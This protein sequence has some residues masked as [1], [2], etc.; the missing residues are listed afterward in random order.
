MNVRVAV[1]F[2]S[3][4]GRTRA[5]AEA[6]ARGASEIENV[7]ATTYDVTEGRAPEVRVRADA[8]AQADAIVFGCPTYMGSVSADMKRFMDDTAAVW[9]LQGWQ[10]KVAAGFTHSAA[11]SGDKLG[12]L[13]QL[14]VFAAQ[15]GMIWV[16]LGLPPTYASA[17]AGARAASATNRLG[18]HLGAMAQSA[19]GSGARPHGSDVG[20]CEHLGRRVA[21]IA[22]ALGA[23]VEKPKTEPSRHPA[24]QSWSFPRG[25]RPE[26]PGVA[27]TNLRELAARRERLEHHLTIVAKLGDAQLEIATASEPLYF[28]HINISDEYVVALP[29]G[30]DLVDRFPLRTFLSDAKT[31]ADVG[32]YNHRIGDLVLHPV[33]SL[34]WPGKLRPPFEPFAI[35]KGMRRAGVSL[36]YCAGAPTPA[37][38]GRTLSVTAGREGDAKAYVAD[39]PPMSLVDLLAEGSEERPKEVA[40]VGRSRL[41]LVVRP[42]VIAPPRGA[43]VVVLEA[44]RDS[45]HHA[46]DLLRLS[47]GISLDGRGI[48]RAL[49]LSSDDEEPAAPPPAWVRVPGAPFVPFEEGTR[50]ALPFSEGGLTVESKDARFAS[51]RI[52]AASAD[53]PKHW[54][55]RML[56]RVAVHGLGLGHVETYGG[57][58]VEDLGDPVR[59]G[60]NGAEPLAIARD[61]ALPFV[62]RL[63]RAV[64]PDGYE[65]LLWQ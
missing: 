55:A 59:F 15:H 38:E 30:D 60:I 18:S 33:G 64:A 40:R 50:G 10:D 51:V 34:H 45:V 6:V 28:A 47:A 29:T 62:E 21:T 25:D 2:H 4:Y 48:E 11:P 14:A 24:T 26:I 56:Y 16:G 17:D 44:A 9:A 63:Y 43:W 57:F 8:L 41:E 22:R 46:S 35:P 27:R 42:A 23:G 54:L 32:R 61:A 49:V 65:E 53:V 7:V 37:A 19:P 31:G 5:L 20:T 13:M 58:Y 12:T 1:V 39:A 52:G 3:Q 36:I